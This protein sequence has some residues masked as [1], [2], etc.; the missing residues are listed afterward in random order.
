MGSNFQLLMLSQNQLK[1][2]SPIWGAKI[3]SPNQLRSQYPK[4][5][6][7]GWGGGVG[8]QLPTFDAESKSAKIPK[9]HFRGVGGGGI[10]LSTFNAESNSGKIPK[11][12]FWGAG[13]ILIFD[14]W[15][16]FA[17]KLFF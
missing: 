2:Q 12:H 4:V 9:S 15:F 16:K 7:G 3:P 13:S 1:S 14:A 5:S 11:S 17:K 6:L 8:N 10:Q